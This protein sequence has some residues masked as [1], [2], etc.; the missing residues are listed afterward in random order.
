MGE[1]RTNLRLPE[2]LYEQIKQLADK[3]MR[4]INAQMVVLLQSAVGSR[5]KQREASEDSEEIYSPALLAAS[6]TQA[7]AGPA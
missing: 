1:V 7:G 4:S 2:E 5:R 3:E 6:T